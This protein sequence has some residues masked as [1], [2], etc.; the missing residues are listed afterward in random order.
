MVTKTESGSTATT[1]SFPVT[2]GATQSTLS[3]ESSPEL[4][5]VWKQNPCFTWGLYV[6]RP[7]PHSGKGAGSHG[8]RG[9]TLSNVLRELLRWGRVPS[10]CVTGY[11]ERKKAGL[12]GL[13]GSWELEHPSWLCKSWKISI[14]STVGWTRGQWLVLGQPYSPST[15]LRE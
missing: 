15:S 3:S 7:S 4:D 5:S 1:W 12:V 8:G 9:K 14:W 2:G 10:G 13:E 6:G 11:E